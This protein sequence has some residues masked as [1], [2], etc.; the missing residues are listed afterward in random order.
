MAKSEFGASDIEAGILGGILVWPEHAGEAVSMLS[1][2]DFGDSVHRQIYG[3]ILSMYLSD[4]PINTVTVMEK[5]G[6]KDRW[7]DRLFA[8]VD[9]GNA[10]VGYYCRLILER[11]KLTK[12]QTLA[13]HI[14]QAATLEE[15]QPL[16]S[17]LIGIECSVRGSEPST[18]LELVHEYVEDRQ[19]GVPPPEYLDLGMEFLNKTLMVESGDMVLIGAQPSV[20]K[21]ALALRLAMKVSETKRVGFFSLETGKKK[22]TH[23]SIST[24]TGVSL[25]DIKLCRTSD[26]DLSKIVGMGMELGNLERKGSLSIHRMRGA[27]VKD[28]QALTLRYRYEVIFVD[29][30]Q[31]IRSYGRSR[32]EE[33]TNISMDL[34][35]IS[36]NEGHGVTIF[37]LAQTHRSEKLSGKPIPPDLDSLKES[38]QLE[39]D[40]DVVMLLYR[41]NESDKYSPRV[42]KVAKNKEG[43][44][45]ECMLDFDGACQRFTE[46]SPQRVAAW[47]EI[48]AKYEAKKRAEKKAAKAG[49]DQMGM[50]EIVEP[51]PDLPF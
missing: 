5:L 42:L 44:L 21:T 4:E 41:A 46:M 17:E 11:N 35:N 39:A 2:E 34:R 8:I 22:L 13:L 10:Q 37:A 26:S 23:R 30:I 20:G 1:P 3:V 36:P 12:V 49:G 16:I 14:A 38:G 9:K 47:R 45:G 40:A 6:P 31:L 29:Y 32:Y 28:I 33:V 15:A 19:K 50:V 18:L 48:N 24:Y 7:E 43:E 27:T 25:K 51:D